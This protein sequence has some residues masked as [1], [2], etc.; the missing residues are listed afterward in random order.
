MKPKKRVI[1]EPELEAIAG[2]MDPNQRREMAK[3]MAR[4]SKQLEFTALILELDAAPRRPGVLKRV[5]RRHLL[6]N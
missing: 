6:L 4:W 3:K 1:M 5:S 2:A